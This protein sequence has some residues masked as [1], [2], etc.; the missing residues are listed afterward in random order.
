MSAPIPL[1]AFQLLVNRLLRRPLWKMQSVQ[2]LLLLE[3]E[4]VLAL[5][6]SGELCWAFDIRG[7]GR[8][9]EPRVLAH[10]VVERKFGVINEIGPT[11]KLTIRKVFQLILPRRD[12][13]S[14]ELKRKFSC[15]QQHI[16]FLGRENFTI[17]RKPQATDGS[18]SFTVFGLASVEKFLAKR[19]IT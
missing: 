4:Q 13:R 11:R 15:E 3:Y 5:I 7:R 6:H 12:V 19:R 16:H 9:V 1:T 10:C 14:T 18:N 17:A 2:D 8:R